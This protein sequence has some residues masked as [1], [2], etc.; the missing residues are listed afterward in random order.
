MRDICWS[1]VN[2][3]LKCKLA[4][5]KCENSMKIFLAG[6]DEAGLGPIM[7]PLTAAVTVWQLEI[8]SR[9]DEET[10]ENTENELKIPNLWNFFSEILS[11]DKKEHGKVII[12]DSKMLYTAGK[13]KPLEETVLTILS[14]LQKFTDN[15]KLNLNDFLQFTANEK[16]IE[17]LSIYPWYELLKTKLPKQANFDKCL[18]R[19]ERL[20][21]IFKAK[22]SGLVFAQTQFVEVS[23]FNQLIDKFQNKSY[24]LWSIILRLLDEIIEK[25]SPLRIVI[26]KQG[27][28]DFYLEL[29]QSSF[30]DF[31]IEAEC[32]GKTIKSE[33]ISDKPDKT[34]KISG[35]SLSR[36][37]KEVK[38][39]FVSKADE[40]SL[41]VALASCFAKYTRELLIDELNE[42]FV[43]KYPTIKPTKGYFKDG[44]RFLS[45]LRKL[46]FPIEKFDSILRRKR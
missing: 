27:G 33:Q 13:I 1:L 34:V 7:G 36:K 45:E 16:N 20:R 38:I 8:P 24:A 26:D 4:C 14:L 29:L 10:T 6:I 23:E 12:T 22:K 28:R 32:E 42:Y 2:E 35:Y 46:K 30:K 41:P 11:N 25:F 21:K 43:Q 18:M 37:G 39:A 31:E 9:I 3:A 40:F 44:K 15:E 17:K 19:S 5:Q